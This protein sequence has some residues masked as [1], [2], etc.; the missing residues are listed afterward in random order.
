MDSISIGNTITKLRKRDGLTQ[1]AL[2]EYLGVSDRAVSKWETG[3]GYPD[4]TL[5]PKLAELFGV[6][7]DY[8]MIGEEKGITIAGNIILDIVKS[9]ESYPSVGMLSNISDINYSMGGCAPNTA[10]NLA[11]IDRRIPI[12]VMGKVGTDENGRFIVS[13]IQKY[14]INVSKISYTST[15]PTSFCDVMSVPS[16]ERTFFHKPGANAEFCPAD[17][18]ISALNCNLFHIGYILLLDMFDAEDP[19]YGTAMARF[20]HDVQKSGIKTSID[21]VSN[22]DADLFAKKVIPALKYCNY[23]IINEIECCTTWNLDPRTPSGELDRQ[24]IRLAM[25]KTIDAGVKDRVVVHCKESSFAMNFKKELIEV[26]SLNVPKEHIKGTVGAG[27][28]FCAGCLYAIYHNYSDK[29]MLEFASAAA[30]CNLL[31]VNSVDGM[32]ERNEILK[33]AETYGRRTL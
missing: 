13:Q 1:S 29:E 22:S 14:G 4:I 2:A 25:E 27:D 30:A 31:E 6:S 23:V 11:K 5:F 15:A 24:N 3:A 9:I 7:V 12:T 28:A 19:Q 10:V 17:I 32:K 33:L 18:D 16:G 8:L 26:P 20:L 21:V